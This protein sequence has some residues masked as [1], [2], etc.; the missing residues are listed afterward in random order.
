MKISKGIWYSF[1]LMVLVLAP[2]R[3][4]HAQKDF[5]D[6]FV[7][8]IKSDTLVGRV[9]NIHKNSHNYIDFMYPDGTDTVFT[10]NHI[11]SYEIGNQRYLV[12]PVPHPTKDDTT[13]LFAK[14]VVEGYA[15]LFQTK[16]KTDPFTAA[17]NAY[18]CKKYDEQNFHPA[19]KISYLASFFSDHPVLSKELKTNAHLYK[20]N[21]ETKIQLF[22]HYNIWKKFH[23]DSLEANKKGESFSAINKQRVDVFLADTLNLTPESKFELDRITSKL[24]VNPSLNLVCEFVQLSPGALETERV[25]KAVTRHL[26]QFSARIEQKI[27]K[28]SESQQLVQSKPGAHIIFYYYR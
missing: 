16:I 3:Y 9:S 18:L 11:V 19:G 28:V 21:L 8:T 24:D 7:I 4:V 27:T 17:D 26:N 25:M 12:V 22:N 6:G 20:N 1:S 5:Q 10:P 13:Y 15:N 14:I 2:L 23:L